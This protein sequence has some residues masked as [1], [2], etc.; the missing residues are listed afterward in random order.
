[1]TDPIATPFTD[2]IFPTGEQEGSSVVIEA[3]HAGVVV[4]NLNRPGRKNAFDSEMIG[5]LTEAFTTLKSQEHVRIV[6]VR[7]VGGAF[8]AGAD[9]AWMRDAADFTESQNREDAM[10]LAS[11]LKALHDLPQLTVALVEGPAFGGGAGLACA[12]D[13]VLATPDALFSFSEVKLGLIPAAISPYVVEAIGARAARRLFATGVR[14]G[15][16]EAE[17]LGL[18]TVAVADVGALHAGARA[19]AGDQ[20]ACAPGAVGESKRLVSDVAGKAIDHGLMTLTAH[21]IAAQRASAEGREGV[22]AFLGKRKP[23]WTT[24]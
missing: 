6:F 10:E 13:M 4:V 11:M 24:L 20:M 7:G 5:E 3:T 8:C 19:L 2:L 14:F 23:G 16:E 12:C 21:R 18:V 1:M 17:R 22:A 9:L 15:A